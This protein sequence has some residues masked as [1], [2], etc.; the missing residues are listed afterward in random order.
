[1]E[2][3]AENKVTF[4]SLFWPVKIAQFSTGII[5]GGYFHGCHQILKNHRK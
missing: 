3:P 1:L 5:F 4:D 2:V